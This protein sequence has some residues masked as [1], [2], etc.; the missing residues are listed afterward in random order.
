MPKLKKSLLLVSVAAL[1][2]V[3][4]FF[5]VRHFLYRP[6]SDS[7]SNTSVNSS[8]SDSNFQKDSASPAEIPE[9]TDSSSNSENP[10][11]KTPER[12]DGDNPNVLDDLTGV[13]STARFAANGTFLVR[14]NI[15]QY[16]SSG[17]CRLRISDEEGTTP[18][19]K[20]VEIVP[21]ASTS[22]CAGFDLPA[23]DLEPF[24]T[25]FTVEVFLS[26]GTKSGTLSTTF[27]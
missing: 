24:A 2:A 12:Y 8:S 1:A 15:D 9:K 18:V 23:S 6:S 19:E 20:S 25:P 26:S 4:S 3:V 16:L 22:T 10:D 5:L 27:E 21:E 13:I 17:S 7:S 14:V 11:G